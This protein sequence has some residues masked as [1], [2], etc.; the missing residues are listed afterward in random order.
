MD[1]L[2][3][4]DV[5]SKSLIKFLN[6]FLEESCG[7][8]VWRNIYP[9][10]P[11]FTFENDQETSFSRLDYFLSS[12]TLAQLLEETDM[13]LGNWRPEAKLDHVQITLQG[14]FPVT[15]GEKR[16]GKPWSIPQPRLSLLTPT[17][18]QICRQRVNL[19]LLPLLQTTR[20]E[21]T[22]FDKAD[23]ISKLL[24]QILVDET[25]AVVGS[26]LPTHEKGK[27]RSSDLIKAQAE[28][29]TISKARDLIRTLY[30]DETKSPEDR[31]LVENHLSVLLDRLCAMGLT[32]VPKSLD[33]KNLHE[34]SE[35]KAPGDIVNIRS[36]MEKRKCT[37]DLLEKE[38]QRK[39][40]LD[41]KKRGHWFESV[42]GTRIVTCPNFVVDSRSGK[43]TF[44]EK[45]VKR[46]YV[47]EGASLLRNKIDL[48][49]DEM[50]SLQPNL[51]NVR[52]IK[53]TVAKRRESLNLHGLA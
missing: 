1:R 44:D 10:K 27:Y 36:Y 42:F 8:D 11:G 12:A 30:L 7:I 22:L 4:N 43:K 46:I 14:V 20:G 15:P 9:N 47:E 34:W 3:A 49:V 31:R 25:S 13:R 28:I 38:R 23:E 50:Q 29:T 33:I 35:T 45:E 16:K 2:R 51:T 52:G 19:A 40:F 32:S 21:Q 6:G 41:P 37:M 26:K 48:P 5:P 17:Q 18:K 53:C 24:A 39:I